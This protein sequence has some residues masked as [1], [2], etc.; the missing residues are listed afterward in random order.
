MIKVIN[1]KLWNNGYVKQEYFLSYYFTKVWYWEGFF[2]NFFKT[3][4]DVEAVI[5]K[6]EFVTPTFSPI[7]LVETEFGSWRGKRWE[8]LI[9][10]ELR[11][12]I[13]QFFRIWRII[14]TVGNPYF[15]RKGSCSHCNC[16]LSCILCGRWNKIL[17]LYSSAYDTAAKTKALK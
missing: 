1:Y 5:G 11:Q 8:Q 4:T 13:T 15:F 3:D 2:A 12:I 7:K 14:T 6:I 10:W 16:L 9:E 17:L